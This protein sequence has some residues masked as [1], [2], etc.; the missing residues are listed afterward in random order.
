MSKPIYV[1][2]VPHRVRRG[3]L[4]PIPVRW[5]G[6]VTSRQTINARAS[7]LTRKLRH[8]MKADRSRVK[9]EAQERHALEGW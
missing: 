6:Q 3:R 2:G 4:V 5:L 8:R 9:R 7:K 1:D